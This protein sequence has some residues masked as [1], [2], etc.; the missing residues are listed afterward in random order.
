MK[1][2]VE[3]FT[4]CVRLITGREYKLVLYALHSTAHLHVILDNGALE[5]IRESARH[6]SHSL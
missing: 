3:D 6:E 5:N 1:T 4:H 2:F